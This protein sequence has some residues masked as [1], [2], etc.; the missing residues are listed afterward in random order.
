MSLPNHLL[1]YPPDQANFIEFR[2]IEIPP[3]ESIELGGIDLQD[4]TQGVEVQGWRFFYDPATGIVKLSALDTLAEYNIITIPDAVSISGSFDSNMNWC[5]AY[6]LN[7]GVSKFDYYDTLLG[8]RNT[9]TLPA[10]SRSPKCSLDDKRYYQS[11]TRDIVLTYIQGNSL[12]ARE[13]RDRFEI[14]YLLS[15]ALPPDSF[16]ERFGMNAK[17]KMQWQLGY[18]VYP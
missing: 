5:L 4:G 12:Y 6:E 13:Q 17:R 10:G 7:S 8:A 3:F 1:S 15:S 2:G 11:A 9:L 18:W 14:E 16:I